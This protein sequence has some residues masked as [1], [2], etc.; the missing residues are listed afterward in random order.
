MN[1]QTNIT[2]NL[3]EI[4]THGATEDVKPPLST[5]ISFSA[6]QDVL[7]VSRRIRPETFHSGK[8]HKCDMQAAN[9]EEP[10]ALL[11]QSIRASEV[12][13]S[14]LF[15][16][17]SLLP[18]STQ[19]RNHDGLFEGNPHSVHSY[20]ADNVFGHNL[21][22]KKEYG[23]ADNFF[24]FRDDCELHEALGPAF[25]AQKQTNEF[26][27][28][29]SGSIKDTT[30]SLMCSRDFNEGDIEH[31]LEAMLTA[32]DNSDDTFSNSTI[33]ARMTPTVGKSSLFAE[34]CSQSE[35][36]AMVVDDPAPWIFP[37]STVTEIDRKHYTSLS[38]S[39]SLVINKREKNDCDIAQQRKGMK[40][41]NSSRRT[42][43]ASSPRQRPRDR[44]LI[45]DRIKELRQIVPNGA[46]VDVKNCCSMPIDISLVSFP[47]SLSL[48]CC[49]MV[50]S[51]ALMVS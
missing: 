39:N 38:T 26:S 44:Q 24:S 43:V 36:R 13:F 32:F 15:S 16:P 2:T 42:K 27:Y 21:V 7:T 50:N 28:D 51:V 22:T 25:F 10:F 48:L 14:D 45:Q 8:E 33:N 6:T 19:L 17:E 5:S 41:S 12:E 47:F 49:L 31:L 46:K 37:E 4:E 29:S 34:N 30:S 9:L 3:L 40:S 11:Y 35:S 18:A 1:E 20:S 23:T